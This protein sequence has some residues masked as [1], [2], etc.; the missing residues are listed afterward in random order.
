M[1]YTELSMI[2]RFDFEDTLQELFKVHGAYAVRPLSDLSG[3][4]VHMSFLQLV[5]SIWEFKPDQTI[6]SQ[7]NSFVQ[8]LDHLDID[9]HVVDQGLEDINRG[10]LIPLFSKLDVIDNRFYYLRMIASLRHKMSPEDKELFLENDK[11]RSLEKLSS[12]CAYA[13]RIRYYRDIRAALAQNSVRFTRSPQSSLNQLLYLHHSSSSSVISSALTLFLIDGITT[14]ACGFDSSN[15]TFIEYDFPMLA[16]KLNMTPKMLRKC[17]LG[18][19]MQFCLDKKVSKS[20][21]Y[22]EAYAESEGDFEKSYSQHQAIKNSFLTEIIAKL[23]GDFESDEIAIDFPEAVSIML[24][25]DQT[26]V[27]E[28]L[29][30]LFNGCVLTADLSIISYPSNPLFTNQRYLMQ[31]YDP[32]MIVH[33]CREQVQDELMQVYSKVFGNKLVIFYPNYDNLEFKYLTFIYFKEALEVALAN[34]MRIFPLKNELKFELKYLDYETVDLNP[35]FNG[36]IYEVPEYVIDREV[37]FVNSLYQLYL[38]NS[39]K[40]QFVCIENLQLNFRS[41]LVNYIMLMVLNHLKYIDIKNRSILIPAA[42]LA[43]ADLGEFQ[44]DIILIFE[45]I[46]HNLLM[47]EVIVNDYGIFKNFE[48]FFN[49]NILDDILYK[50]S[51]APSFSRERRTA[52]SNDAENGHQKENLGMFFPEETIYTPNSN[53]SVSRSESLTSKP[54]ELLRLGLIKSLTVYYRTLK[55]FQSDYQRFYGLD[56]AVTAELIMSKTFDVFEPKSLLVA[57]RLLSFA[58]TDFVVS[59]LYAIDIMQYKIIIMNVQKSL[60]ALVNPY[61]IAYYYYSQADFTWEKMAELEKQMPF[62]KNYSTGAGKLAKV[63]L[64]NFLIYNSLVEE[65][66]LFASHFRSKLS[67]EFLRQRFNVTFDLLEFYRRGKKIIDKL[68]SFMSSVRTMSQKPL[69]ED[70]FDRLPKISDLIGSLIE[71]Y[72][73]EKVLDEPF[74]MPENLFD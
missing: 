50:E 64:T 37:N 56:V 33:Y 23:H 73:A 49:D 32:E 51:I 59:D 42:A 71:F 2:G 25:L 67:L 38:A 34:Y 62:S 69:Y 43:Q 40:R 58:Q 27:E 35:N 54:P 29:S 13:Y 53:D 45:L 48:T 66:D 18:A 3:K 4:V 14:M 44:E 22:L 36:C 5:R 60:K 30:H 21:V 41:N 10:D 19:L 65:N 74:E 31:D 57:T 55:E 9:L 70:L 16:S 52:K 47:D 39:A 24:G 68:Y 63:M 61:K 6:Y 12:F 1:L 15:F 46:K 7:I 72:E 8:T 17:L 11:I 20:S 26:K 28:Y